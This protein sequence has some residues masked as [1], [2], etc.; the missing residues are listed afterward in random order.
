MLH[1]YIKNCTSN[2]MQ[3]DAMQ[4][5]AIVNEGIY[6]MSETVT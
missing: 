3:D 6:Q 1:V 2:I 5:C 4:Y